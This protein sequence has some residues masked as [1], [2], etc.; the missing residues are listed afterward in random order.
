M[1]AFN[2]NITDFTHITEANFTEKELE[3][4]RVLESNCNLK[5]EVVSSNGQIYRFRDRQP[6]VKL[7]TGFSLPLIGLGTW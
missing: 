5:D 7:N 3:A 4:S 6:H 1:S 2:V